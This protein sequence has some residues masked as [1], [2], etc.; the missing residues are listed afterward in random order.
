MSWS[1]SLCNFFQ[2]ADTSSMTSKCSGKALNFYSGGTDFESRFDYWLNKL[3]FSSFSPWNRPYPLSS[4]SL[5]IQLSWSSYLLLN[6]V[7]NILFL[8]PISATNVI[9]TWPD[10]QRLLRYGHLKC[11]LNRKL[12]NMYLFIIYLMEKVVEFS[13]INFQNGRRLPGCTFWLVRLREV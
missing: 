4:R 8:G 5:N 12:F 2:S 3:R 13:L 10:S 1:S 11:N 7:S 6:S 9:W